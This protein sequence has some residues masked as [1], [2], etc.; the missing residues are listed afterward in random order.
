MGEPRWGGGASCPH[1][2][3]GFDSGATFEA[4]HPGLHLDGLSALEEID[5]RRLECAHDDLPHTPRV[6]GQ[7][8]VRDERDRRLAEPLQLQAMVNREHDLDP[9]STAPNDGDA[10][11]PAG[12]LL[13][14]PQKSVPRAE[15]PTHWVDGHDMLARAWHRREIGRRSRVE[16]Q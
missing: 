15:K 11:G 5:P 14:R 10:H 7:Q 3:C 2:E 12:A 4:Q 13:H 8:F 6:R 16:G 1:G 9:R